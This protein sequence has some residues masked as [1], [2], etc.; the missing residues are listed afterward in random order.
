MA[1]A[2]LDI[3]PP[4]A[5]SSGLE[6]LCGKSTKGRLSPSAHESPTASCPLG[7]RV[8]P[9]GELYGYQRTQDRLL[10]L[11]ASVPP[12]SPG[13][14]KVGCDG[15]APKV[16]R[17]VKLAARVEIPSAFEL[18]MAGER[19]AH[20]PLNLLHLRLHDPPLDSGDRVDHPQQSYL[21][22]SASVP[23]VIN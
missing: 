9:S 11:A 16:G 23:P 21:R 3:L 7:L 4:H 15:P 6:R 18:E 19:G 12:A 2:L 14:S 17:D 13:L 8:R 22:G 5:S 1:R 20:W 10:R